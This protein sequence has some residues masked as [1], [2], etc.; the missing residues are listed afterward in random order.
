MMPAD[1]GSSGRE[2]GPATSRWTL[3]G[4]KTGCEERPGNLEAAGDTADRACFASAAV[5]DGAIVEELKVVGGS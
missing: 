5:G 3:S 4:G 1:P 2:D